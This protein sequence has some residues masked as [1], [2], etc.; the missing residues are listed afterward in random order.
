MAEPRSGHLVKGSVL[1]SGLITAVLA[2]WV[3]FELTRVEHATGIMLPEG[4]DA[5]VLVALTTGI[6]WV[7]GVIRMCAIEDRWPW[8]VSLFTRH[9][10]ETPRF[11][12]L[13]D[14][15]GPPG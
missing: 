11:P 14:L 10:V 5:T 2:P 12:S 9:R 6:G 1:T 4:Y 7:A 3:S 15:P 8:P 13:R